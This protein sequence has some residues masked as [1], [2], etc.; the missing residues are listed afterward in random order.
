MPDGHLSRLND[1]EGRCD[2][3][4]RGTAAHEWDLRTVLIRG[5]GAVNPAYR[6][7]RYLH[8]DDGGQCAVPPCSLRS[9]VVTLNRGRD[10]VTAAAKRI[11]EPDVLMYDLH[12]FSSG[13]RRRSPCVDE[14][15]KW[16]GSW[17]TAQPAMAGRTRWKRRELI[18][19]STADFARNP[20]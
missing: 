16:R 19:F 8:D 20:P 1:I 17:I 5:R 7:L 18:L 6:R 13:C 14:A 2:V 10:R 3:M 15:W 9:S 11:D 4:G 12:Q